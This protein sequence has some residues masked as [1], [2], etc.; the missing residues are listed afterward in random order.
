MVQVYGPT[1]TTMRDGTVAFNFLDA[2]GKVVDERLVA[3]ESSEMGMLRTGC[4][5][6]PGCGEDAFQLDVLKML[7]LMLSRE[8]DLATYLRLIGS[9]SPGAV[10]ASFGFASSPK[11]I[12][13]FFAWAEPQ[14]RSGDS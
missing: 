12:D 8:T 4:F 6:N 7:P 11:D 13:R 5:C 1:N 14:S 9:P 10:H 2:A 3:K